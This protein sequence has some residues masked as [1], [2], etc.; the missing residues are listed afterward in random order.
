MTQKEPKKDALLPC[1]DRSDFAPAERLR[2][3]EEQDG[4]PFRLKRKKKNI[5]KR[6]K[7]P[8]HGIQALHVITINSA[9]E[10]SIFRQN[11]FLSKDR[12][13]STKF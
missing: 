6:W 11:R 1:A 10:K 12:I 4:Q 8:D 2:W 7:S 9:G 5:V 13:K 3:N